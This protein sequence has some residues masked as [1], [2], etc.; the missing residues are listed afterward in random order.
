MV[1]VPAAGEYVPSRRTNSSPGAM[2][3]NASA[4][5]R[6]GPLPEASSPVGEMVTVAPL[7]P[8]DEVA[9]AAE[10]AAAEDEDEDDAA[11]ET[12]ADDDAADDA[13]FAADDDEAAEEDAAPPP[14]PLINSGT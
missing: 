1:P 13:A 6:T 4:N 10:A 7:P 8:D 9:A 14:A 2:R 12:T 5:V 3:L 11:D